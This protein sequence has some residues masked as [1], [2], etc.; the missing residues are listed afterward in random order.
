M[1]YYCS[2]VS[3]VSKEKKSVDYDLMLVA[4]TYPHQLTL[5]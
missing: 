5:I 4:S 2:Y 1:L 3:T